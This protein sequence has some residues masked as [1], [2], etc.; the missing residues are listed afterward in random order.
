MEAAEPSHSQA[1]DQH[2]KVCSVSCGSSHSIALLS[3]CS[4]M[5]KCDLLLALH[6]SRKPVQAVTWCCLGVEE[7][8]V[9]SDT[10]MQTTGTILKL[11]MHSWVKE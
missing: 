3:E 7:R 9:S 6:L 10:G 4:H 1:D 11:F 5:G 8:M 2:S